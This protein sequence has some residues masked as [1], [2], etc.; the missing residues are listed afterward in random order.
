[1][2]QGVE[3]LII[4]VV[5][6][7]PKIIYDHREPGVVIGKGHVCSTPTSQ[8]NLVF[9]AVRP[10]F[11]RILDAAD[12]HVPEVI[13]RDMDA[14]GKMGRE[15]ATSGAFADGGWPHHDKYRIHFYLLN[16]AAA[17]IQPYD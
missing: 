7:V 12:D 2:W 1:M 11:P 5:V 15:S 13:N 17:I 14:A 8:R 9:Q 3:G 16:D 6:G 4:G 10:D